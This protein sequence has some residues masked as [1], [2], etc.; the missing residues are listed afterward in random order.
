MTTASITDANG[1][2]RNVDAV[3]VQRAL[4][5]RGLSIWG[6][7]VRE[8]YLTQIADWKTQAQLFIEMRDDPTVG[9]LLN[10]IKL[11]LLKAEIGVSAAS[12]AGPDQEAAIWLNEAMHGMH[13]QSWRAY[14]EDA[15]EALDFGFALGEIILEKRR[16]GHLWPRS[17][18]PRGQETVRRWITTPEDPDEPVGFEQAPFRG[19]DIL[20]T[21][22]VPL[23]KCV[24]VVYRGR[25]GNPQ[26]R[27]LLRSAYTP[28]IFVKNLRTFEGIKHERDVGG[29]PIVKLPPGI[30]DISNSEF[31]DLRDQLDGLK[32]D[33]TLWIS[34]PDGMEI[35]PY[36]G[37][38]NTAGMRESIR[39]HQK[40]ILKIMFAQ[41]LELGMDQAGTQALVKGSH[42]FFT[43]ALEAVQEIVL[44]AWN[45]QLVPFLFRFNRFPGTTGMPEIT[46]APPG[47]NDIKALVELY[48]SGVTAKVITATDKDETFLREAADLPKL[49]EGE[50]LD[51]RTPT[52]PTGGG[53][54]PFGGELTESQFATQHPAGQDLRTIRG[55]Y[56]RFVNGYQR[57]LVETYDTWSR[58]TA[59]LVALGDK[60]LAMMNETVVGRL[61]QLSADLKVLGRQR[62]SEAAGLG[63]GDVLGRHAQRLEVQTVI[64]ELIRA[65]DDYIDNA[66]IPSIRERALKGVPDA[67]PLPSAARREVLSTALATRRA[68]VAQGAGGAV[69]AIFEPQM[70]A[71]KVENAERRQRGEAA[72]PVRWVLDA[73]A[74]HCADDSTRG[75]FGCP[76][77]AR[78]YANG[79]D[80]LPTVPAGNVS[81]LGNCRCQLWADF[82]KGWERIT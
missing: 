59:R 23:D 36:S 34:L 48:R 9:A 51:D 70:A 22:P 49:D 45:Q 66:L 43:M 81:C 79:W 75:T 35:E 57:S 63:M 76:N 7:F 67:V 74:E 30:L 72:I 69:T 44:E 14:T 10:A 65:N 13:R 17:I 38:A 80:E 20:G 77:L 27:S 29:T 50:A 18:E 4:G 68:R 33:E 61:D 62:I 21:L 52:E 2:V 12:E 26:G 37:Q 42:D 47:S 19:S 5:R 40:D 58:E 54:P 8:E 53:F 56:E 15:L 24:H 73:G 60:T 46:W 71:G 3:V 55:T 41:F 16:D 6:G 1:A 28:Y 78:V 32:T 64:S 11:P 31:D 82:G 25:K 39:D